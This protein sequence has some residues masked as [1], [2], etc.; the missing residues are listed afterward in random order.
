M[1]A[2]VTRSKHKHKRK[3]KAKSTKPTVQSSPSHSPLVASGRPSFWARRAYTQLEQHDSE[4]ELESEFLPSAPPLTDDE[5]VES[6]HESAVDLP[7]VVLGDKLE[8]DGVVQ[9]GRA[10]DG[11]VRHALLAYPT[12]RRQP[13]HA[14]MD[15]DRLPPV[16][17]MSSGDNVRA[18]EQHEQ[19]EPH[20]PAA[21]SA[22]HIEVPLP[23]PEQR[24]PTPAVCAAEVM[25]PRPSPTTSRLLYDK[26]AA[27]DPHVLYPS[28]AAS[29]YS[30]AVRKDTLYRSTRTIDRVVYGN[31][32]SNS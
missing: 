16:N 13:D 1:L 17:P 9:R 19:H 12:L 14:R 26:R 21:P 10:P 23:P 27:G 11:V 22:A 4:S 6:A 31:R 7:N 28:K 32:A 18:Q 5:L 25:Y 24:I 15:D 3:H 30:S 20:E 8:P 2:S 29:I